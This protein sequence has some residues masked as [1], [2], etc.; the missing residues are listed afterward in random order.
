MGLL[1]FVFEFFKKS[2]RGELDI[3]TW[4]GRELRKEQRKSYWRP[5]QGGRKTKKRKN[6]GS[7]EPEGGL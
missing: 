7:P 2:E 5:P 4:D 3:P 1:F 6:L